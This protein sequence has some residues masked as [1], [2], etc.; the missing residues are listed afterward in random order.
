MRSEK[1]LADGNGILLWD[2]A[3]PNSA[4]CGVLYDTCGVTSVLD[5]AVNGPSLLA[6]GN[7]NGEVVV[8]DLRKLSSSMSA[9]SMDG[10]VHAGVARGVRFP[11][12]FS[13]ITSF[14]YFRLIG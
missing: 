9:T 6:S 1:A 3:Q 11:V 2:A 4:R 7:R 10:G 12:A 5:C 13:H 14:S 8:H